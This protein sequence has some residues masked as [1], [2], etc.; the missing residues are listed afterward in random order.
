MDETLDRALKFADRIAS[1]EILSCLTVDEAMEELRGLL[2]KLDAEVQK[3]IMGRICSVVAF[4]LA[5]AG[6]QKKEEPVPA[7]DPSTGGRSCGQCASEGAG[8]VV[9]GPTGSDANTGSSP[10]AEGT[11]NPDKKDASTKPF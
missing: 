6:C 7:R 11:K 9:T 1:G 2:S 8:A 4:T 3:E 10:T 5:F